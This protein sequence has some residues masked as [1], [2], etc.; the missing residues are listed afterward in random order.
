MDLDRRIS[1][2]DLSPKAHQLLKRVRE[3]KPVFLEEG[4]EDEAVIVD[5]LDYRLLR[6]AMHAAMR[7]SDFDPEAG[8][9]EDVL[10]SDPQTQ[11]DQ[12]LAHYLSGIISLGRASELLG[13]SPANL[14]TRF[15]R[16]DLPRRTAPSSEEEARSDAGT[17]LDWASGERP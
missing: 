10:S 11:C 5:I 3:G 13:V 2:A 7:Q 9:S 14:R 4:G 1:F 6:A 15:E 17:A 16:L 8:L 12:I